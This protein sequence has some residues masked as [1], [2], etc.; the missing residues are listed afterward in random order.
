MFEV[1]AVSDAPRNALEIVVKE[2]YRNDIIVFR[3]ID[4][5]QAAL[6]DDDSAQAI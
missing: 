1:F 3:K 6:L 4:S 5:S 2:F